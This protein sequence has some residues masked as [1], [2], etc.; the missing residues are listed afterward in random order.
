MGNQPVQPAPPPPPSV[1]PQPNF[2]FSTILIANRGEVALRLIRTCH[3]LG[4]RTVAVF[5]PEDSSSPHLSAATHTYPLPPRGYTHV[6]SLLSA[7]KAFSATAVLPGYGF[8]SED[9]GAAKAFTK[10]GV[11]WLGPSPDILSTFALKHSAREVAEKAGVPVVPGSGILT[12]VDEAVEAGNK[13]GW[14]V[15]LKASGG[16]GGM[17]QVVVAGEAEMKR[18]YAEVVR[19][20]ESLFGNGDVYGEKWVGGARHIEVQVFGDGDSVVALGVR[21]CSVQRRRQKVVEEGGVGIGSIEGLSDAAVRLAKEVGYTSAGTVEFLVDVETGE[22]Y[23]LEV[24]TRLQVEH[25]VTEMVT[26]VDIVEWMIRVGGGEKVL[27]G[28][29]G[30]QERGVAI[31]SRLYAENPIKDYVPCAGT[32]S[33]MKWPTEGQTAEG[34]RVR[35]DSWAQRGTVVPPDY[36]PLLGKVICWGPTRAHAIIEMK[37]ALEQIVVRGFP[38]NVELLKQVM[39]HPDFLRG[40]Y[41]TNLLQTFAY[42]TNAIEVIRP[43]LQTSL[44][45]YPGRVGYWNIGVS[46]SG[47]MDAYAMGMA[48]ALVGNPIG[49]CAM[50]ITMTGPSLMFHTDAIVALTGGC[51]VAELDD[52]KPVEYWTP[53]RVPSGSTLN[54]G[55]LAGVSAEQKG[56]KIAYL[57]IRGGFDAPKYLGSSSTFPTGQF[58]GLTGSFLSTGDFLPIGDGVFPDLDGAEDRGLEFRWPIGKR[59]P[60]AFIPD[61]SHGQWEV[62]ALNGPHA[63]EDFLKEESL[64]GIWTTEYE[65][66]HATNRLG[67]RLIGPAPKWTREDGGSAGLHPSN[68]HDYTYAPGAVNFSGNTPIVLMLD[69]PSLGGFV[70]PITVASVELWKVAQAKPGETVTFRQVDFDDASAAVLHMEE[71]WQ[72]VRMNDLKTLDSLART[73][74]P[75]WVHN[76]PRKQQPAVLASLDPAK[77]DDAEIKVVYRMSGDEHVLIEYGD[78]NL[79][80]AYRLRVHMLMEQLKTKEYVKELCPGVRSVLVRYSRKLIH[81]N[82]LISLFMELEKGVLGSVELVEVPSRVINL[83]LAFNDQWTVEAQGRYLRSVRPDAP[84]MPSNVEFVRRINGLESVDDVEKIMN[85]AEYMVLGLGDVYL[86][87]PCA[88][89]V[90]PRHRLVTS[91]YNP[92][93]TFTPEGAVGIGG[94]YM[95]IYGM[96]SPGGY[97][98]TGRTLPIWDNY[99]SIPEE[100][101]GAPKDIPWLLRFFDRVKFFPVSDDE[102][103]KLRSKYRKGDYKIQIKEEVFKYKDHV[104]FCKQNSRTIEAFER[105]RNAAYEK[106]RERWAVQGEGESNAAAQHAKSGIGVSEVDS[107]SPHQQNRP[108]FSVSVF[109]GMSASVWAVFA[110]DGDTVEKGTQLFSLESMKVEIAIE[111]PVAGI[112]NWVSISKGDSVAPDQ[113]LCII[114]S[115]EEVASGDATIGHIRSL[116]KMGIVSPEQ[117]LSS[118]LNRAE[119]QK[120][121]FTI[122]TS[123]S[124]IKPNLEGLKNGDTRRPYTPL[125]GIPFVVSDDMSIEGLSSHSAV[126]ELSQQSTLTLSLALELQ[127][128]G[129]FLIGKTTIDQLNIGYSGTETT[130]GTP[131][132]PIKAGYVTGGSGSA[133]TA[134]KNQIASFAVTI[135]RN[136]SSTVSPAMC[137]I[138]GLK[139]TLGLLPLMDSE[140]T[141]ST[142]DCVSIYASNAADIKR[143]LEI[144]LLSRNGTPPGSIRPLPV[145]LPRSEFKMLKLAAFSYDDVKQI[146]GTDMAEGYERAI[147][148]IR[149]SSSVVLE[150]DMTVFTECSSLL[151]EAPVHE[152]GLSSLRRAVSRS[153][154]S[155]LPS[156]LERLNALDNMSTTAIGAALSQLENLKR[157]ADGT[158]W[159][160]FDAAILPAF[161][162]ACTTDSATEDVAASNRSLSRFSKII[163]AMGLCAITIGIT[164][165]EVPCGVH[166]VA[167]AFQEDILLEI[168]SKY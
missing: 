23:F 156:V 160:S 95:C 113:E 45:D 77:G 114:V 100:N 164:D 79:D 53:F 158:V 26:G 166:I 125:L 66:H 9:P 128:A 42:K 12:S 168:A 108:P 40:E 132:N 98:L 142:T 130:Q 151:D 81:V 102:L 71:A 20:S 131:V 110:K 46:P 28:F 80:L 165:C 6:P 136:G 33:E 21:E 94:A 88:V 19:M 93:R 84:Y 48:N 24:N 76:C 57:A 1:P 68:L 73:W 43:G 162:G 145:R 52:G 122:L 116:F 72:A 92:A 150:H 89:P 123:E 25:A 154:A 120:E 74:S 16:G 124:T 99:G 155:V 54:I 51:F 63:S 8:V 157:T 103:E 105:K 111:A 112:V 31:Q 129:A 44:Q 140:M 121:L 87:A 90:D 134:V 159:D 56:G 22:W 62:G 47:P 97:Q 34:G 5:T 144:L 138:A 49:T 17:G 65:V 14:P 115:S 148:K 2:P 41:T 13:I 58:G 35:I 64:Q 36:D 127:K 75:G 152:I 50:E 59:L 70:C 163:T 117:V 153:N 39:D 106:E 86:G 101:R 27:E 161:N 67:A 69:G 137:G 118:T 149:E 91:K 18:K 85:A 78:I 146:T 167:P 55:Q 60:D 3:L 11:I 38:C 82:D 7:A 10:A 143:V 135:D 15:L 107:L 4:L 139:T 147:E 37:R 96:D 104:Q 30:P 119:E 29:N 61:Y 133:A 83:P 126:P 109:A 32:L 141:C